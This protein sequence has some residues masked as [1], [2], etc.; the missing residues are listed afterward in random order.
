MNRVALRGLAAM[1]LIAGAVTGCATLRVGSD[2]DHQASFGGF[3]TFTWVPRER[4]GT[5]NPLVVQRA[6]DAIQ[7]ELLRKG[8]VFAPEAAAADFA[9]DFTIGSRVRMDVHSYPASYVGG[10]N[11]GTPGWWG[12]PYWGSQVDIRQYREGTLSVDVFDARTHRPVWHGWAKKELSTS[13]V[14]RSEEPIR[15]AVRAILARFPPA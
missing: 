10:W 13:D 9:V 8:Y 6:R 3:H 11:W 15:E 1:L 7:A 2:Y 14:E 5:R 4:Y 12:Y